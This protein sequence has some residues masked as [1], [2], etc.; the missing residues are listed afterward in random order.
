MFLVVFHRV[1]PLLP[2]PL[3]QII[4]SSC[5][6]CLS[7]RHTRR[8]SRARARAHCRHRRLRRSC[9]CCSC[10]RRQRGRRRPVA[11][12]T[13]ARLQPSPRPSLQRVSGRGSRLL[14]RAI[15]RIGVRRCFRRCAAKTNLRHLRITR[16]V[17]RGQRRVLGRVARGLGFQ[18]PQARPRESRWRPRTGGRRCVNSS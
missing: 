17:E 9:R 3:A 13:L 5:E 2:P 8:S 7:A 10:R 15:A 12:A 6:S 14:A 18:E 11:F 4:T 16:P 1:A